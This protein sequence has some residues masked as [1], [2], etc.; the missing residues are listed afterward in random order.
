MSRRYFISLNL[1][2]KTC[3]VVGGGQVAERKVHTL[4]ECSAR[5]V[6]VSPSITPGLAKLIGEDKLVYR[7]GYYMDSDLDGVFLVIGA[8][9]REEVNRQVADDCAT[10]NLIV[11]IVDDQANGDFF[12]P[13]VVRRGDLTIAVSTDGKSPMLARRIRED[14]EKIYGATFGEFLELLGD[15][16]QEIIRNVTDQDKKKEILE[17]MVD[18]EILSLLKEGYLETVKERLHSAYRGGRS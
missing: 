13:A 16:R 10:R 8:A 9:N 1:T 5:V 12:V 17:N 11:N 4:L 6:V 2:G 7:Q 18:G 15:L 3:L 14:L